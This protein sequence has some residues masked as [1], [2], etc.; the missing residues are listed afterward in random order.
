MTIDLKS[1]NKHFIHCQQ[2]VENYLDAH[3]PGKP[4]NKA[5]L[6]NQDEYRPQRIHEA[7]RYATLGGG[8]RIR[9]ILTITVAQAL[10]CPM[11]QALTAACAVELIH[12]YSLIHDD[13]PSMDNDDLRRGKPSCHKEFG[14]AIAI[15]AGDAL[16]PLAFE[17]LTN[18]Q[19]YSENQKLEMIQILAH[20]SGEQGMVGGQALDIQATGKNLSR[21]A[22]ENM[23]RLKTG[24]LIQASVLTGAVCANQSDPKLRTILKN[25]SQSIGLAFQVQDDILDITGDTATL[26]KTQGADI[27]EN[28][29]TYPALMGIS[30]AQE[31]ALTLHKNALDALKKTAIVNSHIQH[32]ADISHFIIQRKC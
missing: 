21:V 7:I 32:L 30:G 19:Q 1:L 16:Q 29:S 25:Y 22:L 13:L 3:L 28:K 17:W 11:E 6:H 14:E 24:A 2:R 15:L 20:A 31:L 9:P 5:L 26:G 4:A 8:K 23:H 27:S 10:G 18:D 12:V